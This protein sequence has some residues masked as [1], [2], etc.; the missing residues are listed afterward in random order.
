MK[1]LEAA[2]NYLETILILSKRDA[3][4]RSIDLANELNYSKPTIS[5]A[6]KQLR[7]SGYIRIDE[8]GYITL[9]AKGLEIALRM[10]ERHHLIAEFLMSIGVDE[11]TAYADSCKM[12]HHISQKSFARLKDFYQ[13]HKGKLPG[14]LDLPKE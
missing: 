7:K 8:N 3:A 11:E 6:M 9:T 4:V 12:E 1:I 2:E 5:V 10:Y 13:S 14:G